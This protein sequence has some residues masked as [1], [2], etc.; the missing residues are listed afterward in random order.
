M[1]DKDYVSIPIHIVLLMDV[2]K[3]CKPMELN[4]PQSVQHALEFFLKPKMP[5][6][7][8]TFI[9]IANGNIHPGAFVMKDN[10]ENPIKYDMFP[11]VREWDG[12]QREAIRGIYLYQFPFVLT[13]REVPITATRGMMVQCRVVDYNE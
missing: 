3:K 1:S 5:A 4:V 12:Y 13:G 10:A 2:Y 8:L 7:E 9:A 6:Q 11:T